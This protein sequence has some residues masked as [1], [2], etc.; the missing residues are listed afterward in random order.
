MAGPGGLSHDPERG[1]AQANG[2]GS[3]SEGAQSQRASDKARLSTDVQ[4]ASTQ[5]GPTD[6]ANTTSDGLS[7][8]PLLEK[9]KGHVP[10]TVRRKSNTVWRFLKGPEPPR[11]WKIRPLLPGVQQ[12]PLR[13]VDKLCPRRWQRILALG[14][15]YVC[16]VATF[17]A[18]LRKSSATE[19]V[20]G[21]GQPLL[22]GCGSTFW[23]DAH[24][25]ALGFGFG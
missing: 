19:D 1:I 20:N 23:Y 12:L 6:D 24:A 7:R 3:D 2:T 22:T 13:L 5:E 18:V 11:I 8:H 10:P 9:M 15:F 25:D 4:T 14:V 21:Y 16:W 17:A